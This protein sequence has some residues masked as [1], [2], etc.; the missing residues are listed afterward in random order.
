MSISIKKRQPNYIPSQD[1]DITPL[2]FK[3][4]ILGGMLYVLYFFA[5]FGIKDIYSNLISNTTQ[6]KVVG[7]NE[8]RAGSTIIEHPILEVYTPAETIKYESYGNETQL[9]SLEQ[10]QIVNVKYLLNP[11]GKIEYLRVNTFTALWFIP[12]IAIIACLSLLFIM[13]KLFPFH[14]FYWTR[15]DK[16]FQALKQNAVSA[17]AIVDKVQFVGLSKNANHL[18][19]IKLYVHVDIHHQTHQYIS[20]EI[21]VP[22]DFKMMHPK[23]F[24]YID[25]DYKQH[26]ELDIITFLNK[27]N[28][29]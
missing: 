8:G 19:L 3:I 29:L 14:Y 7:F 28:V 9:I 1:L 24:I 17:I 13:F 20:S 22:F 18:Q 5:S 16:R 27:N 21:E 26:F 15:I 10:D 23:V 6:A 11:Q 4:V 12:L 25:P 2:L